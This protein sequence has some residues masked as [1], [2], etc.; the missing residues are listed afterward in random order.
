LYLTS[1]SAIDSIYSIAH[2]SAGEHDSQI[3]AILAEN[4]LILCYPFFSVNQ[5]PVLDEARSPPTEHNITRSIIDPKF[6]QWSKND[7]KIQ[8][9]GHLQLAM[10]YLLIA[11]WGVSLPNEHNT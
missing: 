11:I 2:K 9:I 5:T 3:I 10:C 1:A 8:A 6:I 4:L 7:E